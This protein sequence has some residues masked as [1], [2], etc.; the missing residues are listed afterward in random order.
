MHIHSAMQSISVSNEHG[1]LKVSPQRRLRILK[2]KVVC[3]PIITKWKCNADLPSENNQNGEYQIC[4]SELVLN[5]AEECWNQEQCAYF[6][7]YGESYEAGS[8]ERPSEL[9]Q[10]DHT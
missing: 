7:R 5:R 2:S 3:G 1:I 9:N 10:I 8:Y 4:G 6:Y